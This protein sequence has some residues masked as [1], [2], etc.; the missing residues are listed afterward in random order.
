MRG[1]GGIDVREVKNDVLKSEGKTTSVV[2][3]INFYIPKAF[4]W[5]LNTCL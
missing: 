3:I 1:K 2:L 4:N 5:H